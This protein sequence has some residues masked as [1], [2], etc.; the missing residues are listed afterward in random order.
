MD[1]FCIICGNHV[2]LPFKIPMGQEFEGIICPNCHT[3]KTKED[4]YGKYLD[5]AELMDYNC[6]DLNN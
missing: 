1:E 6:L 4:I 5:Y 2:L 3:G